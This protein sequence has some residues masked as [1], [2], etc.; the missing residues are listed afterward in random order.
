MFQDPVAQKRP[1]SLNA[2]SVLV[3]RG[4]LSHVSRA[5]F[6]CSCDLSVIRLLRFDRFFHSAQTVSCECCLLLPITVLIFLYK[7]I[8]YLFFMFP[9]QFTEDVLRYIIFLK[10]FHFLIWMFIPKYPLFRGFN[11]W[12]L[13]T[14]SSLPQTCNSMIFCRN[15]LIPL[16][17]S[18]LTAFLVL[19]SVAPRRY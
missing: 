9:S 6:T 19:F 11:R 7:Y 13:H 15:S 17:Y 18:I 12:H 16:T 2:S 8:C 1:T 5:I 3:D 14:L 10:F 4:R